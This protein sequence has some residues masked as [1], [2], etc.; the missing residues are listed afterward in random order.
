MDTQR[1]VE[2]RRT[3][4]LPPG[5]VASASLPSGGRWKSI[6]AQ[7]RRRRWAANALVI[8][9]SGAVLALAMLF[10]HLLSH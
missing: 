8:G 10:N 7:A 4:H 2:G 3:Q 5:L 9:T 1:V 6:Q